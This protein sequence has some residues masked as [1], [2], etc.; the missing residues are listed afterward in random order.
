MTREVNTAALGEAVPV[1]LKWSET[2]IT[3]DRKD[4]P[5]HIL[6]LGCF[7]LIVDPIIGKTYLSCVLMDGGSCLNLLYIETYGAMGLS[8]AVIRPSGAPFHGVIPRLQAIPLGQVDLHMTFRGRTNFYME[9]L[10]FEIA[11]FHGSYHAI[12]G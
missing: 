3:F 6:Q 1:F 11:N 4:H 5:D 8:R 10:T 7:P 9:T 12:L 2:T